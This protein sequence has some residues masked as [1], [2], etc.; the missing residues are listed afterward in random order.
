MPLYKPDIGQM[1]KN[2]LEKVIRNLNDI[3]RVINNLGDENIRPKAGIKASKI[4][5]TGFDFGQNINIVQPTE[6]F[7]LCV[8]RIYGPKT[9]TMDCERAA[10]TGVE[11][12]GDTADLIIE[13]DAELLIL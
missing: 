10:V 5:W 4:D 7:K 13:D 8:W 12:Y 1:G 3:A 2:F 11:M 9:I 6:A